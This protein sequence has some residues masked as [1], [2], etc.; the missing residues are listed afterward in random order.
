MSGECFGYA[1][2][3]LLDKGALDVFYTPIQMKK[4][5]PAYKLTVLCKEENIT[6]V[7]KIIFR[8]TSTIGMRFYKA[9][10]ECM[11]REIRTIDSKYGKARVKVSTFEDIVKVIPEYEDCK[12]LAIENKIA[13]SEIYNERN[14]TEKVKIL[15]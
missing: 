8:E 1:M 5:R 6:E 14:T 4:N 2:E 11:E 10:R 9:E 7:K 3:M 13:L 15:K 12:K